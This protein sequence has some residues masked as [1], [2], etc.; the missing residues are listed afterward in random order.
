MMLAAMP[1]AP[2]IIDA[3]ALAVVAA[4]SRIRIRASKS[5]CNPS[6]T[7]LRCSARALATCISVDRLAIPLSISSKVRYRSAIVTCPGNSF[8][9]GEVMVMHHAYVGR[10]TGMR[11]PSSRA[12]TVPDPAEATHSTVPPVATEMPGSV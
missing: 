2:P 9:F 1:T 10:D 3:H 4:F 7:V 5:V 12:V 11:I 8:R 6:D